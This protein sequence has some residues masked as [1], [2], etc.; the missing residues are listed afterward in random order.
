MGPIIANRE[1]VRGETARPCRE[2]FKEHRLAAISPNTYPNEA[3]ATHYSTIHD[4]EP[5]NLEFNILETGLDQPVRRKV[6]EAIHIKLLMPT[7]NK[8]EED[9]PDDAVE[10]RNVV[11]F[12]EIKSTSL[13]S[14]IFNTSTY[15]ISLP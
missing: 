5:P 4:G 7:I 13:N 9:Y 2:R 8:K 14:S 3:L 11:Q 6:M 10:R 12:P 15:S 1:V